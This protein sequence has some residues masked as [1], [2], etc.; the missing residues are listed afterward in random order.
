MNVYLRFDKKQIHG[1]LVLLKWFH[2]FLENNCQKPTTR[3]RVGDT[4]WTR[5][6]QKEN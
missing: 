5:P 4:I 6:G 3:L 2:A 1:T